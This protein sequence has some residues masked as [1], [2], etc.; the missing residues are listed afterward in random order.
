M[1]WGRRRGHVAQITYDVTYGEVVPETGGCK[2]IF[3]GGDR[4][5][6]ELGTR[7]EYS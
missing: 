5:I 6:V 3:T 2:L 1:F 7:D 4:D